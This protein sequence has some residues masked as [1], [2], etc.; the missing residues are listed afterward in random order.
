ML[1]PAPPR[2]DVALCGLCQPVLLL[3]PAV[4][5]PASTHTALQEPV[6]GIRFGLWVPEL[7]VG[8]IGGLGCGQQRVVGLPAA[9]EVELDTIEPRGD[10]CRRER[11]AVEFLF[12]VGEQGIPQGGEVVARRVVGRHG[13]PLSLTASVLTQ[14]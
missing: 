4:E 9:E 8:S 12:V 3:A 11:K 7:L 10:T 6:P 14:V 5:L 2:L 1:E 13:V